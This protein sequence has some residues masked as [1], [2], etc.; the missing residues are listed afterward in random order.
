[1]HNSQS[2]PRQLGFCDQCGLPFSQGQVF[3]LRCGNRLTL[4]PPASTPSP[5]QPVVTAPNP[6]AVPQYPAAPNPYAAPQHSAAPNPFAVPQYPGTAYSNSSVAPPYRYDDPSL[7]LYGQET[8]PKRKSLFRKKNQTP[9]DPVVPAASCAD[10]PQAPNSAG[11]A[12][13]MD[14]A[15]ATPKTY[16]QSDNKGTFQNTVSKAS[17]YWMVQRPS[18]RNKPPFLLYT[19]SSEQSA[20]SAL[21]ALSYIHVAQDTGNLICAYMMEYGYYA[22]TEGE[23]SGGLYE[24][25]ICGHDL[26]PQRFEETTAAF[27]QNG[28]VKKNDQPPTQTE[29]A[30]NL[31][32]G[33]VSAVK[34]KEDFVKDGNR[35][36]VYTAPDKASALAYLEQNAV[37]EPSYYLIVDTPQ[38]GIGRDIDGIYEM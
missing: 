10:P 9:Q 16:R 3:C 19:F 11:A 5:A 18:Q 35:Y 31:E 26:T 14:T 21:L 29:P 25:I 12:D 17:S 38:G 36:K 32:K 2:P 6:F 33:D 15:D 37:T 22:A 1:M 7:P 24:A 8:T 4:P 13:A 27:L 23:N 20:R 28:G 34:Y 30:R